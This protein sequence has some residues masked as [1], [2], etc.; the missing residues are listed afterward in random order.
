MDQRHFGADDC[1][2]CR[3][4]VAET[5][6]LQL[7]QLAPGSAELLQRV[8]EARGA[9]GMISVEPK[10]RATTP[11]RSAA[12]RAAC[13]SIRK[14]A[15]AA[16]AS[17]ALDVAR[18][19]TGVVEALRQREHARQR[20]EI[21]AWLHRDDPANRRPGCGSSLP[22]RCQ[23]RVARCPRRRQRPSRRSS[24]RSSGGSDRADCQSGRPLAARYRRRIRAG[25]SCR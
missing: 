9:P 24:R 4:C 15:N 3:I 13:R 2:E 10:W 6:D 21:Q 8:V 14:P 25:W 11:M 20:D 23:W 7:D 16:R 5:R 18:Q 17:V 19:R 22:C 12:T 1:A